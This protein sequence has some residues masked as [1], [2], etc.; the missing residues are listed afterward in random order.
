MPNY[1]YFAC[2]LREI[3]LVFFEK[4]FAMLENVSNF[5]PAFEVGNA[6]QNGERNAAFV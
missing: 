6:P 3:V 4:N 1:Q 2:A 5:A